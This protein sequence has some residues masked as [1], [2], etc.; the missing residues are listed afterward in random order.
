MESEL[1]QFMTMLPPISLD[2]YADPELYDLE[3]KRVQPAE[4]FYL[5]LA[6]Q[7]GGPVLELG[8]GTG[9]YTIP[10]AQQGIDITGLDL[11]PG[12]LARAKA[13]AGQLPIVWVQ[14]DARAFQL[15]RQFRLIF[16]SGQMFQHLLEHTE[17]VQMLRCVHQHLADEGRFVVT[18]RVPTPDLLTNTTETEQSWYS[19]TTPA[20]VAVHVSGTD[21]YDPVRQVKT[22]TAYRR[23]RAVNGQE[24]VKV[25][26]LSLRY[27]H[28]AEMETL[29]HNADF[30]LVQCFGGWDSAQFTSQ[31][32]TLICLCRKAAGS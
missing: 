6:Q 20:G 9:H 18:T 1:A 2:D 8:C 29:L 10:L 12:M 19:Y 23:W 27:T 31:S 32:N 14:A 22:E 11:V 13:K 24:V 5:A 15:D 28:P 21:Q 25:A 30:E 16:E 17:Q 4:P 26:P 7:L 3:N